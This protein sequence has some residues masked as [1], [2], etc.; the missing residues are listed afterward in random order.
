M[1]PVS[2]VRKYI[3]CDVFYKIV[4]IEHFTSIVV[5]CTACHVVVGDPRAVSYTHL[6]SIIVAIATEFG[7]E[8]V[9]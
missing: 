2:V 8:N 5:I 9:L 3:N 6:Y 1:W 7:A 4:H